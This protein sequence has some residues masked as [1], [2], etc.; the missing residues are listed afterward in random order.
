[1]VTADSG[2]K[3][4]KIPVYLNRQGFLFLI[5]SHC[6]TGV[7]EQSFVNQ[8]I[9]YDNLCAAISGKFDARAESIFSGT[10]FD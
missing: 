9:N 5:Q 2:L 10:A 6:H 8:M 4:Q 1:M 7:N 3:T